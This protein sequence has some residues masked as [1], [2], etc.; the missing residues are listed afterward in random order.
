MAGEIDVMRQFRDEYLL[1]NPAG[2]ALV[3]LY[4]EISPPMAEFIDENPS[5]KPI[6]RVGLVPAVALPTVAVSTTL[7]GK[8]A[9]AGGL[10]LVSMGLAV[11]LRR[12]ACGRGIDSSQTILTSV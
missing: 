6:V 7:A 10:A 8:I 12:R 4:Y 11:W 2:Q 3:G 1:T 5:L 9:I